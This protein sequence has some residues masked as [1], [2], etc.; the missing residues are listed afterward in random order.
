MIICL[1]VVVI[2]FVAIII[3]VNV[4]SNGRTDKAN[5]P[6]KVISEETDCEGDVSQKL[7]NSD[8]PREMGEVSTEKPQ[9]DNEVDFGVLDEEK[10]EISDPGNG[11]QLDDNIKPDN[12]TNLGDNITQGDDTKA[13]NTTSGDDIKSDNIKPDGDT[14]LEEEPS[15]KEHWTKYY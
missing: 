12:N 5:S 8:N 3:V 4:I 1:S 9:G 15:E 7:G 14:K 13:D 2:C 11:S 10:P 6:E